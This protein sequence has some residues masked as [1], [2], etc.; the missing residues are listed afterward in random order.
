MGEL[1][2][3]L[4][5]SESPK[6]GSFRWVRWGGKASWGSDR[7]LEGEGEGVDGQN[8]FET[9]VGARI[10]ELLHNQGDLRISKEDRK[11]TIK[12]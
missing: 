4:H 7:D 6:E 2:Y 10:R 3:K 5:D 1:F 9:M 11:A 8:L 12:N